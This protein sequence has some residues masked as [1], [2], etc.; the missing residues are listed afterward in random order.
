MKK[1]DDRTKAQKVGTAFNLDELRGKRVYVGA[2][3]DTSGCHMQLV[4]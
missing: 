3:V 1:V 4:V 2:E